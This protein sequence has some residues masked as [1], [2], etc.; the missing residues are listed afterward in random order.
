MFVIK[1]SFWVCRKSRADNKTGARGVKEALRF[2]VSLCS[3]Q[4]APVALS[5]F[6]AMEFAVPRL[7]ENR[8]M[9]SADDSYRWMLHSEKF[10][11]SHIY[12]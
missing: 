6:A 2:S 9:S 1:N 8:L 5:I 3:C 4:I 7:R 11:C 10:L 12:G